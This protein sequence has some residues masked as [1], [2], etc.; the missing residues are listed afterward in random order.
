MHSFQLSSQGRTVW[1][2]ILRVCAAFAVVFIHVSTHYLENLI[3]FASFSWF[4]TDIELAFSRFAVPVFVMISGVFFLNPKRTLSFGT[5]YGKYIRRILTVLVGWALLRTAVI[6]IWLGQAPAAEWFKDLFISVAWY[7]FL[8]MIIGLYMISPLLRALTELGER[9]LM[10]YFMVFCLFFAMFLPMAE[11]VE[12]ILFPGSFY[13]STT[14]KLIKIP[15]WMFGAH[16]LFGYYAS[17][18]E[19]SPRAKKWIYALA[20]V[21]LLLLAAGTYGFFDERAGRLYYYGMHGASVTPF[22][23]F[24]GAGVFLFGKDVLG[25][26]SFS[27]RVRDWTQRLARYSLGV[28]MLHLILVEAA[29]HFSLFDK[30]NGGYMLT[31][32]LLA[33]TVFAL[34]NLIIALIYKLSFFRKHF[35]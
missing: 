13:V 10:V 33:M 26:I 16:F 25:K 5:L 14:I 7:W 2:D 15:F 32:P 12:K 24:M 29:I 6:N 19:I 17:A 3:P 34:S 20:A 4:G 18:Y 22:T 21:S 1:L 11:D 28:Y 23:F 8:P 9:K 31:V 35:L 27:P 30:I